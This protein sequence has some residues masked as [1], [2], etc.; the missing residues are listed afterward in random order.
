M[1]RQ[2]CMIHSWLCNPTRPMWSHLLC[3]E[4]FSTYASVGALL[5]STRLEKPRLVTISLVECR[6]IGSLETCKLGT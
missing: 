6:F 5:S 2:M 3:T 4:Q 1:T